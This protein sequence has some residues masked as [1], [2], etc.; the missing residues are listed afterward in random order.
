MIIYIFT[1]LSTYVILIIPILARTLKATSE[2]T[3]LK[4]GILDHS[5]ESAFPTCRRTPP[6]NK[7]HVY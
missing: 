1:S 3:K 2:A 7:Q 6:E 4:V 5:R